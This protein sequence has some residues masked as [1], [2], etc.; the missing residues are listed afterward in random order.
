MMILYPPGREKYSICQK[1]MMLGF[2]YKKS[3][4]IIKKIN[5][6]ATNNLQSRNGHDPTNLALAEISI[7][8]RNIRYPE[9]PV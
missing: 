9:N 3:S 5:Y 1:I 8:L 7:E 4:Q 6:K 2:V